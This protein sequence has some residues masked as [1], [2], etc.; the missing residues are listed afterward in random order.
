MSTPLDEFR[1]GLRPPQFRLRTLLLAMTALAAV[2]ASFGVLG[3]Y[4][5]PAVILLLLCVAA[6]VAGAKLG[7]RLR[8]NGDRPV[9]AAG[10]A[11]SL[12]PRQRLSSHQFA[13]A[14]RL[15][16]RYSLGLPLLIV[17][18]VGVL[19]GALLGGAGLAWLNW[20]KANAF[21]IAFGALA[22]GVLGGIGGFWIGSFIHVTTAAGLEARRG[23]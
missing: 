22:S 7:A 11:V 13:P 23:E 5:V 6:H 15:S 2:F 17:T 3:A 4:G 1:P 18:A 21:S 8:D 14:T 16:Q 12:R 19:L 10:N 9:D 20:E